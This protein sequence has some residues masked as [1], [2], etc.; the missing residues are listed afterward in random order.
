MSIV[1]KVE[2]T[3]SSEQISMETVNFQQMKLRQAPKFVMANRVYLAL[4]VNK[5]MMESMAIMEMEVLL[6]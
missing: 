4:K 6:I 1:Q 2:P 5:A 3:S